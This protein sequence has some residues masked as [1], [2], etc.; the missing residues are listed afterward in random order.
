MLRDNTDTH[1]MF[2]NHA[3]NNANTNTNHDSNPRDQSRVKDLRF[4]R[5]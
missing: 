1:D 4:K 2:D 5:S 3:T